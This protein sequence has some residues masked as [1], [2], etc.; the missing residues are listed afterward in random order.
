[1]ITG[2]RLVFSSPPVETELEL[3][4]ICA[5]AACLEAEGS[6]LGEGD[7]WAEGEALGTGEG[8]EAKR[9]ICCCETLTFA[10]DSL[11][12]RVGARRVSP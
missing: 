1:M 2:P 9:G 11:A 3:N 4:S 8:R 10:G 7:G 12:I 6:A 5:E